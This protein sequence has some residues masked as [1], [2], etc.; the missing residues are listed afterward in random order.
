MK[1]SY[2]VGDDA[3]I[4]LGVHRGKTTKSKV[5]HKFKLD[6]G[7]EYYVCEVPT[8]VDPLLQVR[9]WHSMA[10][11]EGSRIGLWECTAKVRKGV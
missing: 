2:E 5:V 3:W 8:S 9:A 11:S 4:Y 10:D 1:K 6:Y 7:P